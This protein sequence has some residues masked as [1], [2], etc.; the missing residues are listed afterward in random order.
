[1]SDTIGA[2]ITYAVLLRGVNV[3][4][5]NRVPMADLRA[6]LESL[7]GIQVS[8]YLQSGNAVVTTALSRQDLCRGVADRFGVAVVARTHTEL[9]AVV[10]ANPFLDAAAAPTTLHVAF[11]AGQPDPE[12]FAALDAE[13]FLPD[14]LRLGDQALYLHYPS[15]AG[16]SKLSAAVL[17]RLGVDATARNWNTVLALQRL[18]AEPAAG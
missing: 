8:T 10:D 2:V 5:N 15:G 14:E 9:T 4:G 13:T 16:R 7:G 17:A 6:C 11:L 3:G 12:R 1:M 18:T